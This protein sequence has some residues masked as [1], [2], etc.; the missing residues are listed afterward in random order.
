MV[1]SRR[2]SDSCARVGQFEVWSRL[3]RGNGRVS[4]RATPAGPHRRRQRIAEFA[5][6]QDE[7][8]D[9]SARRGA[10]QR[11]PHQH[12]T[13]IR[14]RRGR[15]KCTRME[16][17]T[18]RVRDSY[19]RKLQAFD[20]RSL[21]AQIARARVEHAAASVTAIFKQ[22]RHGPLTPVRLSNSCWRALARATSRVARPRRWATGGGGPLAGRI[23]VAEQATGGSDTERTSSLGACSL[24]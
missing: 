2:A 8:D 10:S 11:A 16:G 21:G 4:P 23:H 22:Q 24:G 5:A 3:G 6:D 20:G 1:G 7:S 12:F 9:S 17:G 18:D 19:A 15:G 13:Y 14:R